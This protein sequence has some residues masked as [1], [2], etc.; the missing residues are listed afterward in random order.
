MNELNTQNSTVSNSI[1]FVIKQYDTIML[2]LKSLRG[3]RRENV[4]YIKQIETQIENLAR[5]Y[6]SSSLEIKMYHNSDLT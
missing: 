3:E 1:D 6:K 4:K 2:K 5:K